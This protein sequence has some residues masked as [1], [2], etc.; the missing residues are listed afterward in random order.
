METTQKKGDYVVRLL[1]YESC[2]L[3]LMQKKKIIT[4]IF[5]QKSLEYASI[6]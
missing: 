1:V 4:I 2:Y 6:C 3:Y 5:P